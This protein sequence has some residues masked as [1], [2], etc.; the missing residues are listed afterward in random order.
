MNNIAKN[1]NSLSSSDLSLASTFYK[2]ET[3][4]EQQFTQI[5]FTDCMVV[6]FF[7]ATLY[8]C[9]SMLR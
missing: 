1:I 2:N 3:V 7:C 4:V 5:V 6:H 9:S 8:N